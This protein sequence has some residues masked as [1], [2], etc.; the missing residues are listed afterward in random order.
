MPDTAAI[1]F[2]R[3]LQRFTA[4]Y[5]PKKLKSEE[6]KSDFRRKEMGKV[7]PEGLKAKKTISNPH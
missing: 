2:L 1:I 5:S 7:L 4:V 6:M 3:T